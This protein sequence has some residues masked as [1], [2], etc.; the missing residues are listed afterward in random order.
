MKFKNFI[1]INLDYIFIYSEFFYVFSF[2]SRTGS[3]AGPNSGTMARQQ[4][5]GHHDG[6]P[7]GHDD[8]GEEGA[9]TAASV[10]LDSSSPLRMM[11]ISR[12]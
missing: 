2:T 11:A 1:F 10:N 6:D 9:A 12:S 5:R 3:G 8:S 7:N 4:R